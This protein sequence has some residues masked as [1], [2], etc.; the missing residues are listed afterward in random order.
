LRR[1]ATALAGLALLAL[2]AT[3]AAQVPVPTPTPTPPAPTPTPTPTPPPP[4]PQAKGALKLTTKGAFG[5]GHQLATLKGHA[6]S[7]RGVLRPFV[8]GQK[9]TV[10]I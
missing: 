6:F 9:V 4:P 5:A 7:I 8:A 2:P 3:A 10:R 1:A